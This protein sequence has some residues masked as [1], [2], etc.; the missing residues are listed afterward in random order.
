MSLCAIKSAYQCRQ[1]MRALNIRLSI[2]LNV[3][4]VAFVKRFVLYSIKHIMYFQI[5]HMLFVIKILKLSAPVH[6]AV[7]LPLSAKRLS[8][9]GESYL[10][11]HL[12]VT[13]MSNIHTLKQKVNFQNSE[14]QNMFKVIWVQPLPR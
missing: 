2:K 13:F 11:V 7:Q 8:I 1:T 5:P 10:A 3:L 4:T 14:V 9:T 6:Q 12:T